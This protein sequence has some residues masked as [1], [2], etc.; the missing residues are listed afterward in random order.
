MPVVWRFVDWREDAVAVEAPETKRWYCVAVVDVVWLWCCSE[1]CDDTERMNG[2]IFNRSCGVRSFAA[3]RCC[4]K[5][6]NKNYG[7][8]ACYWSFSKKFQYVHASLRRT[9]PKPAKTV[10]FLKLYHVNG[11]GAWVPQLLFISHNSQS[12]GSWEKW[13][14]SQDRIDDIFQMRYFP[15]KT[16]EIDIHTF[17]ICV[18]LPLKGPRL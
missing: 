17:F 15:A 1:E 9:Y 11:P 2:P 4:S 6:Q 5:Q 16:A 18:S 8:V 7:S 12:I 13:K 14:F 10:I 3:V